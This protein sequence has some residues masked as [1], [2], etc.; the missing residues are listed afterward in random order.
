MTASNPGQ[1]P[2]LAFARG[3]PTAEEIAA[4]VAVLAALPGPAGPPA[5]G[6][7]VRSEWSARYRLLR[8]PL[9]RGPG[10]WRASTLPR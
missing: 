8:P 6:A 2:V 1:S 5:E 10:A 9:Q 3:N 4:V 7:A